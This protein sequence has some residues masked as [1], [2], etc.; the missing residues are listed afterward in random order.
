MA[1]Q[2]ALK[3][4]MVKRWFKILTGSSATAVKQGRGRFYSAEGI[5][6]Y[7]N[8]LTGKV[9]EGTLLD[10]NGIP[11]SKISDGSEVNFPIAVFQYALGLYDRF[12]ETNEKKY[13][14][15]FIKMSQWIIENQ[16]ADGSWDCFGPLKSDKYTIS[17]MGQGEGAS[18]LLRAYADTNNIKYLDAAVKAV[19]FMLIPMDEGG[20]AVYIDDELFLEEYPQTPKRS[21]LNG[22]IFSLFGIYDLSKLMP[23]KYSEIFMKC[24]RTIANHLG[25]YD[26]GY[27]SLYDLEKRVASP[28]YHELHIAL[29]D[30]MYDISG[31]KAFEEYKEKFEKYQ[32]SGIKKFRAVFKKFTQKITEHSDS[33][34]VK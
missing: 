15:D 30:V 11:V 20:T 31:I 27:W 33:V 25:D 8:D 32:K 19:D 3:L 2:I 18:V 34:I 7:Y 14:A 29:L 28:A 10:G 24:A 16:R 12:L 4:A 21:V 23:E 13:H 6:G 9:G 22:W 1:N 5:K 17:S 26:N